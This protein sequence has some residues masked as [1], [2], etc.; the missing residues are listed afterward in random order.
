[1][2]DGGESDEYNLRLMMGQLASSVFSEWL[3]SC[4]TFD[5]TLHCLSLYLF[6]CT[7]T[8]VI[9][10]LFPQMGGAWIWWSYD[11]SEF[12]DRDFD[13]NFTNISGSFL[14]LFLMY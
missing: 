10:F 5:D 13:F 12:N 1:M 6:C 14:A 9:F 11:V 8:Q 3:G 4:C 2:T 7:A